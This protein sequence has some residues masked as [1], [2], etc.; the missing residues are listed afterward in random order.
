M[1]PKRTAVTAVVTVAA[2]ATALVGCGTDGGGSSDPVEGGTFAVDVCGV[3]VRG[4]YL[5]VEPPHRLV[6]SWG[7]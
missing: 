2:L 4:R 5:T 6:F 7:H 3:A 1:T